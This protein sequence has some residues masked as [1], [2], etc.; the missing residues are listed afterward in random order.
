M[1]T[2]KNLSGQSAVESYEIGEDFIVVKFKAPSRT[3]G[4]LYKYTYASTG[5]D[6]VEHMKALAEAGEGLATFI[7]TPAIRKSYESKE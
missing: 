7:G 6:N 3:G 1:Q 5:R 4:T 2:Y